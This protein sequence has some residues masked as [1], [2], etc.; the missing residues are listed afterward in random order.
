MLP[1]LL[2]S[3]VIVVAQLCPT[4][5]DPM[6]YST[7]GFPVLHHLP[8]FA[9]VHVHWISNAVQPSHP[10]LLSSPSAFRFSQHQVAKVLDFQLQHQHHS[11]QRVFRV[12]VP[13][14]YIQISASWEPTTW[15][16][17]Q[18]QTAYLYLVTEIVSTLPSRGDLIGSQRIIGRYLDAET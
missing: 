17:L 11:F 5:C 13:A 10:L 16:N 1:L 7:P 18:T 9:Q 15:C 12:A 4:L 2:S 3:F 8:G 14:G 6:D